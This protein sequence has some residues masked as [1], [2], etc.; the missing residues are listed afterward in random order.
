MHDICVNRI[1]GRSRDIRYDDALFSQE[2]VDDGGFS[3]IRLS[4]D[5]YPWTLILFFL[6]G[7]IREMLRHLIQHI[8]DPQAGRRGYGHRIADSQIIELIYIRH[9]LVKIIYFINHQDYRLAGAPEHVRHLGIRIYQSLAHV[10]NEDDH[11]CR[12]DGNLCLLAHLGQDDVFALRL[13]PA[14]INQREVLV[15]PVHIRVDTVPGHSG[16]ILDDGYHTTCQYIKKGRFSNIG[17]SHNC[18]Y[19][20]THFISPL[21]YFLR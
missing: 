5:C 12:V 15:K 14:C 8:A 13:D 19:W 6:P 4:Y 10:S 11:V 2:F 17:S 16:R 1:P 3:Y 20:F 21:S 7:M 9:K 18:Y